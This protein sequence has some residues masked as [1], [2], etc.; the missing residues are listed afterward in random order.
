MQLFPRRGV[1]NLMSKRDFLC[2]SRLPINSNC[3]CE[4]QY[5][6]EPK[7]LNAYTT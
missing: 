5:L 1:H 4:I 7:H 6:G 2:C 3:M